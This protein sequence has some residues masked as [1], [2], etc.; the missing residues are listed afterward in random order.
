MFYVV[1]VY[2]VVCSICFFALPTHVS[3]ASQSPQEK[4]LEL[5][6]NDE[7]HK[8]IDEIIENG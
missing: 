5:K 4:K 2:I 6:K 1:C 3:D 8:I 7:M